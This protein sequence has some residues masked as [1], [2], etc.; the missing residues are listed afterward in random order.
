[1]PPATAPPNAR[2]CFAC[3]QPPGSGLHCQSCGRNLVLRRRLPTRAEWESGGAARSGTEAE[4][5]KSAGR[6]RFSARDLEAAMLG[7]RPSKAGRLVLRMTL[8]EMLEPS[9]DLRCVADGRDSD[10]LPFWVVLSSNRLLV[11]PRSTLAIAASKREPHVWPLRDLRELK[12]RERLWA[13][14]LRIKPADRSEKSH[15][16]V[17]KGREAAAELVRVADVG[18]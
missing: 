2:V 14:T 12:A 17:V 6:L 15:K 9:E 18:R 11:L 10:L 16:Y 8:A 3:G 1:L 4:A 13:S 7:R 5:Q